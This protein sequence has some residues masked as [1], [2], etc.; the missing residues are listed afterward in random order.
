MDRDSPL[1]GL[2]PA[3]SIGKTLSTCVHKEK[4][5]PTCRERNW[6]RVKMRHVPI[7]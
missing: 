1:N 6:I 5:Q 4:L 3:S 7:V 2:A